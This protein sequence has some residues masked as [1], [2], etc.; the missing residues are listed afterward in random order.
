VTAADP[1]AAT[2]VVIVG[3]PAVGKM[4][5]GQELS[6]LTG[7]PLFFNHRLIDLVTDYLEFGSRGFRHVTHAFN[8]QF[9]RA[10]AGSRRPVIA[11]WGWCF[12]VPAHAESIRLYTAP[13]LEAGGSAVVAELAAPLD[14]RLERNRTEN[15]RR[16][17]KTEWATDEALRELDRD[18]R[19]N[20]EGD[21]PLDLPHAVFDVATAPPAET[22][23]AIA[24][25]FGLA[26]RSPG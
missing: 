7:I 1:L 3:P 9:F 23:R 14:V 5:V 20:S 22:A 17:K 26:V 15:R 13:F 6:S 19:W 24:V 21:F 16:H 4:T 10:L 18:H 11:T 8:T 2:L 12:D 25:R